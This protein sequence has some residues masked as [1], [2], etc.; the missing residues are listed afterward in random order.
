MV[1]SGL[2]VFIWMYVYM[3]TCMSMSINTTMHGHGY[4]IVSVAPLLNSRVVALLYTPFG[5]LMKWLL[6][7]TVLG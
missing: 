1:V 7:I 6:R 3:P 2:G 5:F 4:M